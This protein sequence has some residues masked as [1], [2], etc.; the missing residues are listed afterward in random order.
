MQHLQTVFSEKWKQEKS[1]A[2]SKE[3]RCRIGRR[4]FRGSQILELEQVFAKKSY[5]SRTERTELAKKIVSP[6]FCHCW[7][8]L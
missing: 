5:L 3:K 8:L 7:K 4:L 6:K 2:P 1:K